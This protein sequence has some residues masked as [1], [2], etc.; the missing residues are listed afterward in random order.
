MESGLIQTMGVRLL[1]DGA[2]HVLVISASTQLLNSPES[3]S[4]L[5]LNDFACE[6][7]A[8]QRERLRTYYTACGVDASEFRVQLV[9]WVDNV[10]FWFLGFEWMVG[11]GI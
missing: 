4:P 2:G 10:G 5:K 11:F 1:K 7:A 9:R 3:N 8:G 6:V